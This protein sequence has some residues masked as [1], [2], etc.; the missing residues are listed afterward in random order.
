[1]EEALSVA[2]WRKERREQARHEKSGFGPEAFSYLAHFYEVLCSLAE[3][4]SFYQLVAFGRERVDQTEQRGST[5]IIITL[6][7]RVT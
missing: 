6:S 5:W 1:V 2:A 3:A 4:G 7:D